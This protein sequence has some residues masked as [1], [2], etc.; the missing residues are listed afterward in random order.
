[1]ASR[2]LLA[3]KEEKGKPDY[4]ALANCEINQPLGLSKEDI[5][6]VVEKFLKIQI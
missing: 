2:I 4:E 1:M 6:A 3:T 5:K